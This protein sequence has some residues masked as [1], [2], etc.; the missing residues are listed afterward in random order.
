MSAME[1][2][3]KRQLNSAK[4]KERLR[5]KA[6]SANSAQRSDGFVSG[7]APTVS[8]EEAIRVFSTGDKPT[9]TPRGAQPQPQAKKS[10]KKKGKK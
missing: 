7:T 4:M 8:E 9:K 3:L 1:A 2:Q 10:G 5:A 6:S